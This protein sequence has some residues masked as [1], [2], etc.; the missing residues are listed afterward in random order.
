MS[1]FDMQG[2]VGRYKVKR[3]LNDHEKTHR[4]T[5]HQ[6]TSDNPHYELSLIKL[7]STFVEC[8]DKWYAMRGFVAMGGLAI[9]LLFLANHLTSY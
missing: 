3:P 7:N 9:A 5:I 2:M 4:F 6:P 1:T 8:V